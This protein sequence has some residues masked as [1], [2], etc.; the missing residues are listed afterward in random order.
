MNNIFTALQDETNLDDDSSS[1]NEIC[2]EITE[3]IN[4]VKTT[5][6]KN[7]SSLYSSNLNKRLLCNT[8]LLNIKCKYNNS[9]KYAHS[10]EDQIIDYERDL[11]YKIILD[12]NL[13]GCNNITPKSNEI[14]INLKNF[15]N[16]CES[17]L[18]NKCTG[19]YNCKYGVNHPSLKL[20]K[21]DLFT[22]QCLNKVID[23]TIPTFVLDK[24]HDVEKLDLYSGCING[25]HLSDRGMMPYY[26]YLHMCENSNKK[27]YSSIRYIDLNL[28]YNITDN[29]DSISSSSDTTSSDSEI[30]EQFRKLTNTD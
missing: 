21:N 29:N 2:L 24:I 4:G 9:C 11:L 28:A 30:D 26:E 23:I 22:G 1:D 10:L 20:C 19:G 12:K 15:T 18:N 14:Y 5:S 8:V 17:C 16:I 7:I 25:L 13:F 3:C 27:H 6:I